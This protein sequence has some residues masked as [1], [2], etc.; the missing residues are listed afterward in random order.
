MEDK[1]I[2]QMNIYI[3]GHSLDTSDET[4]INEIFSFN[5]EFDEQVRVVVYYFDHQ[6]KFDLLANLLHIL[7]KDKVEL[8]MKK[9]WL[10]FQENPNIAEINGIEPVE[11]PKIAEA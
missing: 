3:W 9:G 10:K 2:Y 1:E 5:T 4:Y 6:A 11:L 7:E 8:W